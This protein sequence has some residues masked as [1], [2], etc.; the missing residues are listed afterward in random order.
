MEVKKN[1]SEKTNPFNKGLLTKL[2]KITNLI[3]VIRTRHQ[4]RNLNGISSCFTS[5]TANINYPYLTQNNYINTIKSQQL[6]TQKKTVTDI[7]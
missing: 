5:S 3:H 2:N 1:T 7:K 4:I 6:N